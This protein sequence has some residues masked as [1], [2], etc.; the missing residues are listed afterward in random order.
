MQPTLVL[1]A[2][3]KECIKPENRVTAE[4]AVAL[5]RAKRA[6]SQSSDQHSK[7]YGYSAT[8]D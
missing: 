1:S 5:K 7:T 2:A 6:V 3:L 4:S 8:A